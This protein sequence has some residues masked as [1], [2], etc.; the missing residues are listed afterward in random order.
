MG[1]NQTASVTG[2]HHC[3]GSQR[4]SGYF[5]GGISGWIPRCQ[6]ILGTSG[7]FDPLFALISVVRAEHAQD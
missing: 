2:L 4:L 3:T 5:F 7:G 6:F 1:R